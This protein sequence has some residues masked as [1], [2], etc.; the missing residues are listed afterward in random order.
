MCTSL[1]IPFTDVLP[2]FFRP[3]PTFE[4]PH[5]LLLHPR[6]LPSPPS[7]LTT[8]LPQEGN[9]LPPFPH[10]PHI[11]QCGNGGKE[12]RLLTPLVPPPVHQ[13]VPTHFVPHWQRLPCL[14]MPPTHLRAFFHNLLH[15]N[16]V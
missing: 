14:C 6:P 5:W 11:H 4:P 13:P 1:H 10:F 7:S 9:N 15:I 12:D 16:L 3:P 2:P 8:S